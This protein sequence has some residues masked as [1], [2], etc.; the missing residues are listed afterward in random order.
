MCCN[1]CLKFNGC[2]KA[3][4]VKS[5]CCPDC[6]EYEFCPLVSEDTSTDTDSAEDT[7]IETDEETEEAATPPDSDTDTDTEID[8]IED[9]EI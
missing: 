9:E 2:R 5:K 3:K 6:D 7:I 1:Y 8:I 4:K